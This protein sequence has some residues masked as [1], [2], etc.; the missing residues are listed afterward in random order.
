MKIE[1]FYSLNPLKAAHIIRENGYD[2]IEKSIDEITDKLAFDKCRYHKWCKSKLIAI[3]ITSLIGVIAFFLKYEINL[4]DNPPKIIAIAGIAFE[5]IS[6]P[7][8]LLTFLFIIP[9]IMNSISY[10]IK[11]VL[12]RQILRHPLKYLEDKRIIFRRIKA[13]QEN[14]LYLLFLGFLWLFIYLLYWWLKHKPN[15]MILTIAT[16][17]LFV[18]VSLIFFPGPDVTRKE[19]KDNGITELNELYY[20]WKNA[21]IFHRIMWGCITIAGGVFVFLILHFTRDSF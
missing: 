9:L 10:G 21:P 1:I 4:I 6:Y 18:G 12:I 2:N 3:T 19:M 15:L 13:G 7:A 17:G 5:L 11:C 8:V 14:G 20:L 16:I